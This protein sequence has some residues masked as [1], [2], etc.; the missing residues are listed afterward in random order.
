MRR[1]R[2]KEREN[3][4]NASEKD[5]FV[6]VVNNVKSLEEMFSGIPSDEQEVKGSQPQFFFRNESHDVME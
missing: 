2:D 3:H 1:T 4:P 6:V 5:S